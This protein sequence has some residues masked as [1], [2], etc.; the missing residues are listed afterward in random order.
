[1]YTV[2]FFIAMRSEEAASGRFCRYQSMQKKLPVASSLHR[3]AFVGSCQWQVLEI[4][5]YL[6]KL[7][8]TV[9]RLYR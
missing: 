4:A 1:M 2:D 3:H 8:K 5:M 9:T 7:H 6:E